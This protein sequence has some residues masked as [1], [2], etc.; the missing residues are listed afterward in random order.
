MSLAV[1]HSGDGYSYLTR[2]VATGDNP[3]KRGELMADYYTANGVPAGQWHGKGAELLGVSGEV[4]EAQMAASFGEFLH[5]EADKLL[6]ELLKEGKSVDEALAAVRLGRQPLDFNNNHHFSVELRDRIQ[7][8]TMTHKRVPTAE[9]RETL[10]H[11]VAREEMAELY[12]DDFAPTGEQIRHHIAEQKRQLRYPVSG[13]DLTFT[14]AKSISVLWAIGGEDVRKKI[15][16][17][18]QEAV[19]NSLDWIEDNALF[20]RAGRGG[21]KKIDAN[22]MIATKFVHW[23]NRAGH[24]NLHTHCAVLN[25]VMCDDGKFR[26]IDG[27]VLHRAAVTASEHYNK[28]VTDLVAEKLGVDFYAHRNSKRDQPVWEIKGLPRELVDHFSRRRDILQRRRELVEEYRKKYGRSP[29]KAVQYKLAN[30]ANLEVRGAKGDARPLKEMVEDW[31]A[32]AET[33]CGDRSVD[34]ILSD[35]FTREEPPA[36]PRRED[37]PELHYGLA[38]EEFFEENGDKRLLYRAFSGD[39]ADNRIK[40]TAL[41]NLEVGSSTW[42]FFRIQSAVTR[43]TSNWVFES[44]EQRQE[45]IDRL[46]EVIRDDVCIPINRHRDLPLTPTRRDGGSVYAAYGSEMYTSPTILKQEREVREAANT[47]RVNS[48]RREALDSVSAKLTAKRGFELSEDKRAFIEHLLFSPHQ[49]AAGIGAAGTGKTSAMEVVT[50][51]WKADGRNVLGLAPS[52]VAAEELGKATGIETKTL[53]AATH[54]FD[55]NTPDG[56]WT[57]I[58]EGDMILIDEAGMASTHLLH[59]VLKEAEKVGAFVRMVGDHE[60]LASVETGGLLKD[61][62]EITDAPVLTEIHRFADDEEAEVTLAL[63]DGRVEA[64]DWYYDHDRVVAGLREE[65][66]GQIFTRWLDARARGASAVMIAADNN[67][68]DA[69]N[70]LAQ[71]YYLKTGELDRTQSATISDGVTAYVGDTIVTRE[72]DSYNRY[73]HKG[74]KKVKNGDTWTVVGVDSDS[75]AIR[76]RHT[77]SGHVVT[78]S[79]EYNEKNTQLGYASTVH[80]SQ[81]ITV[82]EA[83]VLVS[84]RMDRQGLYV[85]LSRG[86]KVNEMYVAEDF[87]PDMDSHIDEPSQP[88]AR[89]V[90]ERIIARDGAAVSATTALAREASE[91]IDFESE[92]L[93]Y[94][95]VVSDLTH[96]VVA[97]CCGDEHRDV[98]DLLADDPQTARIAQGL[99]ALA[100]HGYDPYEVLP[101]VITEAKKNWASR[102]EDERPPLSFLVRMELEA[103]TPAGL[104]KD[105]GYLW[106]VGLATPPTWARGVDADLAGWLNRSAE[107]LDTHLIGQI[108]DVSSSKYEQL[109]PTDRLDDPEY[110]YARHKAIAALVAAEHNPHWQIPEVTEP[111]DIDTLPALIRDDVQRAVSAYRQSAEQRFDRMSQPDVRNFLT[112]VDKTIDDLDERIAQCRERIHQL[113][114]DNA[115]AEVQRK[116]QAQEAT[117]E[118]GATSPEGWQAALA[119]ARGQDDYQR[120]TLLTELSWLKQ[121]RQLHVDRKDRA[122]QFL[123]QGKQMDADKRRALIE[124]LRA[125]LR[126]RRDAE[127]VAEHVER[128]D[129]DEQA[130]P[131]NRHSDETAEGKARIPNKHLVAL[132]ARRALQN[133]L[134]AGATITGRDLSG[135][136]LT[137]LDLSGVEFKDCDFTGADF[138]GVTAEKVR[139]TDCVLTDADFRNAQLVGMKA[140]RCDFNGADFTHAAVG[141]RENTVDWLACTARG[142]DFSHAEL[143]KFTATSTDLNGAVLDDSSMKVTQFVRSDLTDVSASNAE[144]CF[145]SSAMNCVTTGD[146]PMRVTSPADEFEMDQ[147]N[148]PPQQTTPG[149]ELFQSH[150]DDDGMEL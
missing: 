70:S 56:S 146:L 141:T 84:P 61:V 15:M 145:I 111:E 113:R 105:R 16:A 114:T 19:E 132:R 23:D 118:A 81:G 55:I 43:S 27:Q 14:P 128:V 21:V 72:N 108:A 89:T 57:M 104:D 68:V 45:V 86:R 112:A 139:M 35:V 9:E 138:S 44:D 77:D 88:S 147:S 38:L 60:Q 22:G 65:L 51:A 11:L 13:Y 102:D 140:T 117:G 48:F 20:S 127:K 79:A 125:T 34:D 143:T 10:E 110:A 90:L 17:A 94:N 106:A 59:Y 54:G 130:E 25:R 31:T 119:V 123:R 115:Y 1:L 148:L 4:S 100:D 92:W 121:T 29:S 71:D 99:S 49:L 50:Q 24:P 122:S 136:D 120:G 78:L 109:L 26:T 64:L 76:A 40:K 87:L 42:S 28:Q 91:G 67:N 95:D 46:A 93:I 53:S 124:D 8:F 30:Q 3:R 37:D 131:E 133:D 63:R 47:W 150:S 98:A 135:V 32:Q 107:R 134:V 41:E 80:R 129:N 66:P 103:H 75:G 96:Q 142:V 73:G 39:D 2:Q 126:Q 6:P 144:A 69:L 97:D 137:G 33:V 62:A 52:A 74:R 12:G 149:A 83:Y 7:H 82:D 101:T 116:K 58:G 18:H 5:P 36:P 85:A